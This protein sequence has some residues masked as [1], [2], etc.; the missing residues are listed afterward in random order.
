VGEHLHV[1]RGYPRLVGETGGKDFVFAHASADVE[2]L[3]TALV[4]GAFEY[5][6]QKCSAASRAYIPES[7]WPRLREQMLGQIAELRQGDP[8]DFRNFLCAVIDRK[9]F[10][11]ISSYIELASDGSGAEVLC[12]GKPDDREG[13][14]IPPTVVQVDDP[15][16]RLM[17]EEIFGPVLTIYVYADASYAEALKLCDEGSPYALTGAVF[18]TDRRAIAQADEALKHAAGNFYINDKPTGAVVGQQPFGGARASG[19]NDKAGSMLNLLRWVSA[20]SI[21]ETFAPPKDPAYPFMAEK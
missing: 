15:R 13:Y 20:R 9:A 8:R 3:S 6:G 12:G 5:Q 14:F 4:R 11:K 10:Q 17:V 19:T 18:A 21:K 2:A 16:H 7:L 1:Y